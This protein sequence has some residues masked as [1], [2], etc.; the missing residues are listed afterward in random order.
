[1][2]SAA[3]EQDFQALINLELEQSILGA[4]I[5]DQVPVFELDLTADDFYRDQHNSVFQ[6]IKKLADLDKPYDPISLQSAGIDTQL[7]TDITHAA[8]LPG[9]LNAYIID[10]K[11]LAFRRRLRTVGMNLEELALSA[12]DADRAALL[13]RALSLVDDL[14]D[15]SAAKD[16]QTGVQLVETFEDNQLRRQAGESLG[17]STGFPNL[18]KITGGFKPGHK[19]RAF[20]GICAP[21]F[22]KRSISHTV[23]TCPIWLRLKFMW[24]AII[25]H[26]TFVLFGRTPMPPPKPL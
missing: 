18:D 8:V 4:I 15:G 17:N 25:A 2:T 22:F 7:I 13:D 26:L 5:M 20:A 3:S 10:L 9:R 21:G 19:C 16:E 14:Q 12:S 11:R 24:F 6:S 23:G 1:M